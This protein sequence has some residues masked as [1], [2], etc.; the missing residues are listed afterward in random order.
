M[1]LQKLLQG[2]EPLN[3]LLSVPL[4]RA[5]IRGID[6]KREGTITNKRKTKRVVIFLKFMAD[7][8]LNDLSTLGFT[9]LIGS[10]SFGASNLIRKNTATEVRM[11]R[12]LT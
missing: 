12:R 9:C 7:F 6:T 11:R 5:L 10:L 8:P 4:L 2:A 3:A 1:L